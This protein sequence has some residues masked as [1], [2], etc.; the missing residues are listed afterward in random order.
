MNLRDKL[1]L[2]YEQLDTFRKRRYQLALWWLAF[3]ISLLIGP[4]VMVRMFKVIGMVAILL[5]LAFWFLYLLVQTLQNEHI[6]RD[7]EREVRKLRLEI[8]LPE[9]DQ[10]K[11]KKRKNDD[12]G[13]ALGDDGELIPLDSIQHPPNYK[14]GKRP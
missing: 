10:E 8:M 4:W 14:N 9:E 3:L 12:S 5:V 6:A 1:L 2:L 7:L 13:Y 11:P